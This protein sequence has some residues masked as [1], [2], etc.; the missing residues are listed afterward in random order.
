MKS[1]PFADATLILFGHGTTLNPE[2]C[3]TVKQHAGELRRRGIFAA[4]HE[5]FWKQEP[6]LADVLSRA[7]TPRVFLAPFFMSEGYFC[8]RIIPS[9]LGF[10]P[11]GQGEGL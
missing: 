1:E 2:A 7:Q 8:E 5:A 9:E 11:S 10:C 6:K 4:V 3:A